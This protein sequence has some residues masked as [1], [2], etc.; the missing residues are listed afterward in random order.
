MRT[1]VSDYEE[2]SAKDTSNKKLLYKIYKELLKLD[3]KIN[4]QIK[5]MGQRLWHL[6]KED[7]KR[8]NKH[9]KRYSISLGKCKLKQRDTMAHLL[10][11]PK[12]R[13]LNA[14]KDLEQ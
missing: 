11:W 12:S 13:T 2:L 3:F 8:A 5:K 1:Q 9:R 14:G 10:E 6:I 4:N 7:M